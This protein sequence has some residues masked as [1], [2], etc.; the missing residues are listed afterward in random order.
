MGD[1]DSPYFA[2]SKSPPRVIR[3]AGVRPYARRAMNITNLPAIA[4]GMLTVAAFV[5]CGQPSTARA[6]TPAQIWHELAACARA[7]GDP[8]FPDPSVDSEGQAHFPPGT[9]KPPPATIAA[10]QSIYDRLPASV[11]NGGAPDIQMEIKFAQC[12]RAHGLTDW[13]DPQADGSY[14]LPP[15]LQT[16]SK[17]GPIWDRIRAAWDACAQFNPSGQL[18]VSR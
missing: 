8:T 17:S 9:E 1:C 14:R 4:L 2:A 3:Q 11:R 5:A 13:P 18:N 6:E 7:H 12:M 15:D 10:C 16:D